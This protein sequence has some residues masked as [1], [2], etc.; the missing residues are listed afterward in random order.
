MKKGGVTLIELLIAIAL[1]ATMLIVITNVYVTGFKT[2]REEL[3]TSQLESNAQ[4]ILDEITN[5]AKN[6][7]SAEAAY[8]IYTSGPNSIILKV[9]ALDSNKNILYSNNTMLFDRVIY[10]YEDSKIHKLTLAEPTSIRY[11]ENG[12]NKTIDD[13]ILELNFTYDPDAVSATLV[14]INIS[15]HQE[16]GKINRTISLT[17]KA[18]LR[19]HL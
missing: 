19:N 4:T 5:T 9:P 12:I 10:Y 3:A 14:T 8:D 16:V 2:F 1:L 11:I 17:S 6:A 15:S 18:R 7:Q 13:K